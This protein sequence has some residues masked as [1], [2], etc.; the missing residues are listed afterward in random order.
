MKRLYFNRIS[1]E[2]QDL[3]RSNSNRKIYVSKSDEVGGVIMS[4]IN[5]AGSDL[6]YRYW[7]G[8][9]CKST[10]FQIFLKCLKK[11]NFKI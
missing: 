1:K 8:V 5:W 6:G 7:N 2:R 10:E 11:I 4:S 9:Y 3:I